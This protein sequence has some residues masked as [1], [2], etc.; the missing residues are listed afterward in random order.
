MV[1]AL[2]EAHRILEPHGIIVDVRPLSIDVPLEVIY[3][4]GNESA[5]MIDMSPG[6]PIDL[7]ADQA[8]DTVIIDQLFTESMIEY[9]YFTYYWT[10]MEGM[11]EDI[12]E[13]WKDEIIIPVEVGQRAHML[14]N[15]QRLETQIRFAARMK[16]GIYV[17]L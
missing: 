6:R 4:G 13:N 15:Q 17:K 7:A 1:H 11:E 16:L 2:K 3:K 14:I 12:E 8:V 10:T 5:G 9:F